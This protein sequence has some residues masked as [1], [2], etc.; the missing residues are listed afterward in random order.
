MDR[1][2]NV[3]L[4]HQLKVFVSQEV[5]VPLGL[6]VFSMYKLPKRILIY[7]PDS[8]HTHDC[9]VGICGKGPECEY[10][11]HLHEQLPGFLYTHLAY[12][13]L[14]AICYRI[15]TN[16]FN[17]LPTCMVSISLP[18]LLYHCRSV[19]TSHLSLKQTHNLLD[20]KLWFFVCQP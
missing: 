3:S 11:L 10:K 5:R 12:T 8:K 6:Y 7:L 17:L 4:L 1:F 15:Q 18:H 16:S 9:M 2:L 20:I 13:Q 19:L 14:L